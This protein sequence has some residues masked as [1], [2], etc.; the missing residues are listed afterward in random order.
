MQLSKLSEFTTDESTR[1]M[2][3]KKIHHK[4]S[5]NCFKR[6]LETFLLSL[7]CNCEL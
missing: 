6:K 1:A 2:P 7:A 3:V 5:T 4:T